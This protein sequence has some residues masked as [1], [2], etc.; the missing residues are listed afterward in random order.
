[1]NMNVESLYGFVLQQMAAESYFEGVSLS[2]SDA[3]ERS[4]RR[5][6]N[7]LGY[8]NGDPAFNEGYPGLS[9]VRFDRGDGHDVLQGWYGE[10]HI[11]F[12]AGIRPEDLSVRLTPQGRIVI[13]IADVDGAESGDRLELPVSSW[14]LPSNG[15][16]ADVGFADGRTLTWRDLLAQGVRIEADPNSIWVTG[17]DAKDQFSGVPSTDKALPIASTAAQATTRSSAWAAPTALRAVTETMCS[18][19]AR[20]TTSARALATMNCVVAWAM[21]P[22]SAAPVPMST[23]STPWTTAGT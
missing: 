6:T 5:G 22:S 8:Q 3:I 19:A 4:L 17:T 12:G 11:A 21:T 14:G 23:W 7:R 2:D 9:V 20:A 15:F 13:A 1:M 18:T 16:L 10:Q